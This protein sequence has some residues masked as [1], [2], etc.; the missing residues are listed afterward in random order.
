[1]ITELLSE[2]HL[3]GLMLGLCTF[4][5]IGLFHPIVI[6]SEYYFGVSCWW[7]FAVCGT[8]LCGA[9]IYLSDPFWS[10]LAGVS[11]FSCYWSILEIFEQRERV[12]KGWFPANP[13]KREKIGS[14]RQ[15]PKD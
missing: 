6:K 4:L 14:K 1:M 11:G 8:I 12:R 5:I 3:L 10:T 15:L 13:N 2:H 7:V 9:A